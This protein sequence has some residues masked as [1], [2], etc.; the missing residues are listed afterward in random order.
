MVRYSILDKDLSFLNQN[1]KRVEIT[2]TN[3]LEKKIVH[4]HES[5]KLSGKF[6]YSIE[7]SK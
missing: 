6:S 7:K 4:K 3:I 2:L 1:D 5:S